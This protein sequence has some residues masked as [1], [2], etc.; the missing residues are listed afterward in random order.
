MAETEIELLAVCKMFT[1]AVLRH[2]LQFYYCVHLRV[3]RNSEWFE[4][5]GTN[6]SRTLV[7]QVRVPVINSYLFIYF[8]LILFFQ[9]VVLRRTVVIGGDWH[10]NYLSEL[11]VRI[12]WVVSWV[13]KS[14]SCKMVL[15]SEVHFCCCHKCLVKP[16]HCSSCGPWESI[17]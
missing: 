4:P 3:K 10:F 12:K 13:F 11:I 8:F 17:L 6:W 15:I 9:P 7:V 2:F 5:L 1:F 16:C 14:S